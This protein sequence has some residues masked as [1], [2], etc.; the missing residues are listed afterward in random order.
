M[1]V[2]F[3]YQLPIPTLDDPQLKSVRLVEWLVDEG[4][5]VHRGSKIALIEG[6]IDQYV[7][8]ANGD[9]LLREKHFPAG[10]EI[11]VSTPIAVIAADGEDIP[12]GRPYSLAE[13]IV[14]PG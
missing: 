5:A 13:R 1:R 14:K 4:A 2:S 12:H 6:P 3:W 10:A 7:V 11:E 8:L 9:G